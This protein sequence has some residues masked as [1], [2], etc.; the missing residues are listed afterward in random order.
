MK[1]RNRANREKKL[2]H[3]IMV[4]I[5]KISSVITIYI[6]KI[7]HLHFLTRYKAQISIPSL[8]R[9]VTI[10]NPL[11]LGN[12]MILPCPHTGSVLRHCFLCNSSLILSLSQ[13]HLGYPMF[14][15][16]IHIAGNVNSVQRHIIN[17]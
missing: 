3:F 10:S 9:L 11:P 5:K 16:D 17:K 1:V 14:N 15:L 6:D 7:K 13:K 12:L 2:I 8:A 4:A